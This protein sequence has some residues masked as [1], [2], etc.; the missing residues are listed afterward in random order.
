[1]RLRNILAGAALTLAAAGAL[2]VGSN[3]REFARTHGGVVRL[4]I[5]TGNT[6]GVYYPYGGGLA[7]VIGESLRVQATAEVTAASVD[8]LKL[9]Q[10]RKVDIAFA[11]AD[12]LDDAARGQGA[13]QRTGAVRVRALAVLYPNYTHVATI[14]GNGI[15]RLA[16]LRGR[17]VSTGSPGSGTEVI[18]L[19]TL[20]AA[21]LDPD[22]DIRRQALSVNASV[23][24]L[25]DGKIDAFFWSGGLPTA[26]ILD[27]ASS[28]GITAKLLPNDEAVASLQRQYGP[29][30]YSRLIVPG[31]SYPGMTAEVGVVGVQ[32]V[33]VVHEDMEEQLAY[34][35]ARVLFDKQPELARIHPE[36]RHLSLS[37]AVEGSP[38]PFHRGA[39][40]FYRERG[41]WKQ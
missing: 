2:A 4:S 36:A 11:L 12:T 22:R 33:L 20:R 1:M 18:A 9:I 38:V 21:G 7:K 16:D 19:R 29:A 3:P 35:L 40:R 34:D 13:F 39:V 27:L 32:N 23:D 10:Q 30:L 25:K 14:G 6:G 37:R 26:S 5:A 24:A 28:I 17:V 31:H 15:D 41:A 8:N